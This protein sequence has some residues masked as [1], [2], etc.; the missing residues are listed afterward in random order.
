MNIPPSFIDFKKNLFVVPILGSDESVKIPW[1][2]NES[3]E[4]LQNR[5]IL[6]A[7]MLDLLP[8]HLIP[9]EQTE[10]QEN[11]WPWTIKIYTFQDHYIIS[12]EELWSACPSMMPSCIAIPE[13]KIGLMKFIKEFCLPFL[14]N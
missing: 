6:E 12:S 5:L 14:K 10:S 7:D 1:M 3:C 8:D 2:E 4:D 11:S 9:E 13:N